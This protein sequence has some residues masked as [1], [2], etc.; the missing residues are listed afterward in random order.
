MKRWLGILGCCW[1]V[2]LY[3]VGTGNGLLGTYYTQNGVARSYFTGTNYS[4]I[5]PQVGFSWAGNS[6]WSG[7]LGADDFSVRWVGEIE[8]PTTTTYRFRTYS[9]D[10]I[11]LSIN[12][13][14]VIDQWNDHSP[15][16]HTSASIKYTAGRYPIQIDYYERGGDAYAQLQWSDTGNSNSSYTLVPQKYL[17]AQSTNKAL[18]AESVCGGQNQ[19]DVLFAQDM[20]PVTSVD[21]ANYQLNN[22]LTV[23]SAQLLPMARRVRLTTTPWVNKLAYQLNFSGLKAADGTILL[24]GSL[25]FSSNY[26]VVASGLR[27][28]YYNQNQIGRAYFSGTQ[29][30]RID[31]TLN[32]NW[33]T[34]IP[35][36]GIG[37]DY[38]STRWTGTLTPTQTG[39]Y[40][41]F[42]N[43]DDGIRITLEENSVLDDFN[44]HSAREASS[45]TL[46]LVAGNSYK[47]A[48]EFYEHT[49]YAVAQLLWKGPTIAKA[50]VPGSA[51]GYCQ[52]QNPPVSLD[53]Y[54]LSHTGA[55]VNCSPTQVTVQAHDA[56]HQASKPAAGT[57]V[58]LTARNTATGSGV[59][60]WS[61]PS[62][63]SFTDLGNGKISFTFD[64]AHDSVT[65]EYRY[66]QAATLNFDLTDGRATEKTGT[67]AADSPAD[68]NLVLAGSGFRF[69][70]ASGSIL[71]PAQIAARPASQPIFLQAI[72]T[73]TSGSSCS[74]LFTNSTLTVS[75]SSQ[76]LDPASCIAGKQ[77]SF[78]NNGTSYTLTHPQQG[79]STTTSVSLRFGSNGMAQLD[80]FRYPEAGQILLK[81]SYTSGSTSLTGSSNPITVRPAGFCID[82]ASACTLPYEN[83]SLLT[84][85][86]TAFSAQV[87]AMAWQS[88][89]DTDYCVGNALTQ[90]FAGLMTLEHQLLAPLPGETG[91]LSNASLNLSKGIGSLAPALSEVGVFRLLTPLLTYFDTQ[92]PSSQ[93]EVI[94]RIGAHHLSLQNL[95]LVPGCDAFSYGGLVGGKAGQ[96]FSLSLNVL[97]QNA[98]ND[99]LQNYQ[100]AYARLQPTSDYLELLPVPASGQF[101]LST[102]ALDSYAPASFSLVK[103][104][105][106]QFAT[107]SAPLTLVA[108]LTLTDADSATGT[109]STTGEEYRLGRLLASPAYGP[110][111]RELALSL[112]TQYFDGTQYQLN[113][114]DNCT[115]LALPAT[116][117]DSFQGLTAA[118]TQAVARPA[119]TASCRVSS[120]L[121]TEQAAAT[122]TG[123]QACYLALTAPGL[124]N[125]GELRYTSPLPAWLLDANSHRAKALFGR[126]R[127][128]DRILLWQEFH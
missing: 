59:G 57:V 33:S 94:G 116:L 21:I 17:Y 7:K 52:Y 109:A 126:F 92:I 106:Y 5:D 38:F 44:D 81:A 121:M 60:T 43:S 82:T 42:A 14:V 24:P 53:H 35:L 85:A 72:R 114:A 66:G 112:Q 110:E 27:G 3:A 93:S 73:D 18:Y 65:F 22:G 34:G 20:D 10:G 79:G 41:L 19:I 32:F 124:G 61:T 88:D 69:V 127:G 15:T 111:D 84:T 83:C 45:N 123:D 119:A 47:I 102:Q 87:S 11:R 103:G 28:T 46:S 101:D 37:A 120:G 68:P 74:N 25:S 89:S 49:G 4:R 77:V 36:T 8:F 40:Q 122:A 115:R 97:P 39:S 90:N 51:L 58:Q 12:G 9:D 91:T 13:Q 62:W 23:L 95:T 99:V 1:A 56:S 107:A 96:P 86:G 26:G 67:A 6:P 30:E 117:L 113:T 31:A 50:T 80:N 128:S 55:G 98:T 76:C 71:L 100:G 29:I 2:S 16:Y 118:Q 104:A 75:M 105:S 63:G 70:D 78:S 54:K 125:Q 64:G 48:V 108:R